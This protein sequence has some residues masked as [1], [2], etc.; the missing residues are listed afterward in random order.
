MGGSHCH[1]TKSSLKEATI[2]YSAPR[3]KEVT[4]S[5]SGREKASEV[6]SPLIDPRGAMTVMTKSLG[7]LGHFCTA[8]PMEGSGRRGSRR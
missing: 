6:P 1:H 7:L 3:P 8:P 5:Q 2:I 4:S